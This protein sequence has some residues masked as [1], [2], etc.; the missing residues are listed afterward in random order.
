MVIKAAIIQEGNDQIIDGTHGVSK[1][2]FCHT[3]TIFPKCHVAAV[4]QPILD[5]PFTAHDVKQTL[6]GSLMGWQAGHAVQDL[7]MNFTGRKVGNTALQFEH[8]MDIGPV[9]IFIEHAAGGKGP[10]FQP[11]MIF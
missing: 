11:S 7:C 1:A 9:Q 8:L 4:M 10:F 6:R 5:T 3:G 2:L